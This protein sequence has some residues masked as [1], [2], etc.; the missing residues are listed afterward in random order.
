[1][2]A[3]ETVCIRVRGESDEH[4]V[5]VQSMYSLNSA[6]P[7]TVANVTFP[8]LPTDYAPIPHVLVSQ[9]LPT[10]TLPRN[11]LYGGTNSIY[12]VR[13][14]TLRTTTRIHLSSS[15]ID[16]VIVLELNVHYAKV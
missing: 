13:L 7:S 16:Y 6:L 5:K 11:H 10:H 9:P 14:S 8:P 1:M 4:E 12:N 3:S 2:T 15:Q